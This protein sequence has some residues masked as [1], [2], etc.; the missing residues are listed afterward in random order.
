VGA[1]TLGGEE[2]R[3][4]LALRGLALTRQRRV[5]FAR[6]AAACDHPT[7]EQLHER[8]RAELP[9]LSLATVYKALHLFAGLGLA[10][11]V[12]TPDGRARFDAPSRPHHHLHCRCCGA[13]A[14]VYDQRLDVAVP[15]DLV[16]A[17]GFEIT[18]SEVQLSG[19]CPACRRA[20]A[21]PAQAG[22]RRR[23]AGGVAA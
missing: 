10:R 23:G 13:L 1:A 4:A 17:T 11:A 9:N 14:D 18:A 12:A 19:I 20:D 7:A 3:Q 5:I 15:P 22:L 2:L 6:L 21:R 16:A 8:I